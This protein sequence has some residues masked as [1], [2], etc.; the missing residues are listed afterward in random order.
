MHS[1]NHETRHDTILNTSSCAITENNDSCGRRI[2]KLV[3][4]RLG[5]YKKLVTGRPSVD[6]PS[7]IKLWMTDQLPQNYHSYKTKLAWS[8]KLY[9]QSIGNIRLNISSD[10]NIHIISLDENL[11]P[12]KADFGVPT[13]LSLR[14]KKT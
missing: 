1:V 9:I 4:W 13:L 7:S 11:E 14:R 12:L 5:V 6:Y 8:K 2:R 10:S 3:I